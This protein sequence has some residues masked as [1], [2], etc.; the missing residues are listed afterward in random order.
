MAENPSYHSVCSPRTKLCEFSVLQHCMLEMEKV[1]RCIY[2]HPHTRVLPSCARRSF[3]HHP[4]MRVSTA[5]PKEKLRKQT[6]RHTHTHTHTNTKRKN[7]RTH[8]FL[9]VSPEIGM[10]SVTSYSNPNSKD[11]ES[12]R[13][14]SRLSCISLSLSLSLIDSLC[15]CHTLGLLGWR[16]QAISPSAEMPQ[17]ADNGRSDQRRKRTSSH[18]G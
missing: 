11:G 9:V 16:S 15:H 7:T 14:W 4:N 6:R 8:I 17:R 12:E 18:W 13:R 5:D 1:I 2:P 3:L 10:H